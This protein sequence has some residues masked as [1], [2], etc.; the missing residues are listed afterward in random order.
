[1]IEPEAEIPLTYYCLDWTK[2]STCPEHD[3]VVRLMIALNDVNCFPVLFSLT[4]KERERHPELDQ[5]LDGIDRYLERLRMSHT[6]EA[7]KNSIRIIKANQK[8][9]PVSAIWKMIK[10]SKA[11]RKQIKV[12]QEYLPSYPGSPPGKNY[13]HLEPFVNVRNQVTFHYDHDARRQVLGNVVQAH[14]SDIKR[15]DKKNIPRGLVMEGREEGDPIGMYFRI[16]AVDDLLNSLFISNLGIT[17]KRSYASDRKT[18]TVARHVIR[19][20]RAFHLFAF[21]LI[22]E[23]LDFYDIFLPMDVPE[24]I[25][26]VTYKGR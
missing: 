18:Q 19:F 22:L 21:D 12:L 25:A 16:L 5:Y 2:L 20:L 17:R 8:T 7:I 26:L 15:L 14:I 24:N 4:R 10:K 9:R 6:A 1:V 3:M 13:K 11:L 23:Y